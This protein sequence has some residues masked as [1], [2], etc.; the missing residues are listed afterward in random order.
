MLVIDGLR[1]RHEF[2]SKIDRERLRL[3]DGIVRAAFQTAAMN[4]PRGIESAA[5]DQ[6][7]YA[8]LRHFEFHRAP[9]F[10]SVFCDLLA[11]EFG[12]QRTFAEQIRLAIWTRL[13][14]EADA[15]ETATNDQEF[16]RSIFVVCA[17]AKDE[18]SLVIDLGLSTSLL[19]NIR[20][21]VERVLAQHAT[22]GKADFLPEFG[23]HIAEI[24]CEIARELR[25][26]PWA[27][28]VYRL[29]SHLQKAPPLLRS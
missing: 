25:R 1:Q 16:L 17:L 21:A 22:A 15:T 29:R 5:I 4:L 14:P 13:E 28:Q 18:P 2:Y 10:P 11:N 27:L 9:I 20:K 19:R 8:L 3:V 6:A 23:S 7:I 24:L 26:L 12:I